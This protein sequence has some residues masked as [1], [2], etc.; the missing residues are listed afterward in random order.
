[1]FFVFSLLAKFATWQSEAWMPHGHIEGL[2]VHL[3]GGKTCSFYKT[4]EIKWSF[5]FATGIYSESNLQLHFIILNLGFFFFLVYECYFKY[6]SFPY[7]ICGNWT[8]TRKGP[9]H[10]SI[11]PSLQKKLISQ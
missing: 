4:K 10:C 1:V 9:A 3:H 6:N 5:W 2:Y 11:K 8:P 7:A